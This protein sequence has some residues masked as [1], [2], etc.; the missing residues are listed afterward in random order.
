MTSVFV[1]VGSNIE[2]RVHVPQALA[3][4]ETRYGAL[5]MSQVYACP[6][7]GFEGNDFINLVVA[8]DTRE[9]AQATQAAL[10]EIEGRC[11][12]DRSVKRASRRIDLDLLLHNDTVIESNDL[13]LPR[14]DILEYAFVLAPMA[15]LA[16]EARHPV[17]GETYAAL[18]AAF[19]DR[20]QPLTPVRL[21]TV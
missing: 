3:E 20:E 6:A 5:R 10:R 4:L 13:T 1:G 2:P 14:A 21:D 19:D 7:V 9:S 17:L 15:E 16:P 8:F 18:W 12:R 11:G